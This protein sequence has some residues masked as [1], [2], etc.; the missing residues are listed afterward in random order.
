MRILILRKAEMSSEADVVPGTEP[1]VAEE[2][3]KAEAVRVIDGPF[4]ETKEL[5]V[6]STPE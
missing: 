5:L 3:D 6:G 1:F 4:A 2:P